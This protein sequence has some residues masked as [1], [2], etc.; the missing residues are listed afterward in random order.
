MNNEINKFS[1]NKIKKIIKQKKQTYRKRKYKQYAGSK[2]IDFSDL[3]KNLQQP[4]DS[5]GCHDYTYIPNVID[6]AEQAELEAVAIASLLSYEK[7]KTPAKYLPGIYDLQAAQQAL[8]AAAAGAVVPGAGG[9]VVPAGSGGDGDADDDAAPAAAQPPP[10]APPPGPLPRGPPRGPPGRGPP[11]GPPGRGPPRGPPG[12][13]PP[14]GPPGGARPPRP[15]P[16]PA[17][18][19]RGAARP[20]QAPPR[21]EEEA[22]RQGEDD[23]AAAGG[24]GDGNGGKGRAHEAQRG[25]LVL[26]A[27]ARNKE[28]MEKEM[29]LFFSILD[30]IKDYLQG[31]DVNEPFIIG[32]NILQIHNPLKK[33]TNF[34]KQ[35]QK[36]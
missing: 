10:G 32:G 33:I 17:E 23:G 3:I 30:N 4:V 28:K 16:P 9:A 2:Q 18:G 21:E 36:Q 12:R 1:R 7:S 20:P 29:K 34:L 35:L 24:V 19:P 27:V 5:S 8:A 25:Q 6:P 13:G 22:R 15:P 26:R 31:C 14:R 11:R